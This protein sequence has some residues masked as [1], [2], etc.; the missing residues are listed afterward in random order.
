[1]DADFGNEFTNLESISDVL[2]KGTLRVIFNEETPHLPDGSPPP[3]YS[4]DAASQSL[5]DSSSFESGSSF[6]RINLL[7][8]LQLAPFFQHSPVFLSCFYREW[9]QENL[10]IITFQKL[11]TDILYLDISQDILK[12]F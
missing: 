6:F 7:K 2:D 8:V 1:M 3:S 10:G 9:V 5:D 4:A 12:C 11:Y